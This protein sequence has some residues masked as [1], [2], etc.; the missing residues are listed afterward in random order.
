MVDI[1]KEAKEKVVPTWF[2][3]ANAG[4]SVQGTYVGKIIG[5]KDGYDNEQVIYQLLQ[6]DGSIVNVAFGLNKKFIIQDMDTV[7]FG[8]IVG[9]VYKGK[10]SIKD[11]FGKI[12]EV[13]DFG[14]HQ[15][16]KIVNEKW[17]EENKDNMPEVINVTG[18]KSDAE[19]D[20]DSYGKTESDD[21]PFPNKEEDEETDETEKKS[22]T[23]KK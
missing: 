2:R 9:F 7:N 18:I 12:I 13:N 6:E 22:K 11:K 1:F 10:V 5:Q 16:P 3:F 4:D 15:D 17:L 14:L 19:E 20:Y 23:A 8:Q 21:V